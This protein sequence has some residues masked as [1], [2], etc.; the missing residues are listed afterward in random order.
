[1]FF[2]FEKL[3]TVVSFFFN[4][5]PKFFGFWLLLK[6]YLLLDFCYLAN[7]LLLIYVWLLPHRSDVFQI[8]FICANGPLAWA[9]LAFNQSLVLHK[10][11]QLTSVF[12]HIAPGL[13]S[14]GIRWHTS[15]FTVCES[16]PDCSEV[17]HFQ[18]FFFFFFLEFFFFFFFLSISFG[19]PLLDSIYGGLCFITSSSF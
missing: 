7:T 3:S 5:F 6:D 12:V 19:Q 18:V 17:G 16:W 11:S 8:V 15:G 2:V 10:L 1:M 4:T 13:F 9:I 14:F